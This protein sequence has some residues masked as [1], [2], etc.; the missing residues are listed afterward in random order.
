MNYITNGSPF[1]NGC[2]WACAIVFAARSAWN[3]SRG[4]SIEAC[5]WMLFAIFE[6]LVLLASGKGC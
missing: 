3:Y 6:L 4:K 2:L 5:F 1:V